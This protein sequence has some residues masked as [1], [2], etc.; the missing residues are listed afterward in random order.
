MISPPESEVRRREPLVLYHADCDGFCSAFILWLSLD[1]KGEYRA[2]QY[3]HHAPTNAEVKDREVYILDFSYPRTDLVRIKSIARGLLVLDHHKT[4]AADLEGL[5]YCIYDMDRAGCGLTWDAFKSGVMMRL[6][7]RNLGVHSWVKRLVDYVED[8]DLWKWELPD[9][10]EINASI[11][12]HPFD[13]KTWEQLYIRNSDWHKTAKVEGGGIIRARSQ[14]VSQLARK[15]Y[16]GRIHYDEPME[17]LSRTYRGPTVRIVNSATLQ[18]ELGEYLL[19]Q[20]PGSPYVVIWHYVDG[21]YV[22]SMRSRDDSKDVSEIAKIF[23]GGGHPQAAG[24]STSD[25]YILRDNRLE[26]IKNGD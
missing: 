5:D 13:F 21:K 11:Q 26:G 7:Q 2:V 14:L 23:D 8:R 18:S 16:F 24:F 10:R 1:G 22:V 20:W 12:T 19:A 6:G 9:S 3:G 17:H 15:S 4:A 25:V